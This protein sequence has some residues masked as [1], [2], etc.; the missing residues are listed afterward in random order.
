MAKQ[1]ITLIG[2]GLVGALLAQQLA[3]RGFA[4]EVYEKYPDPRFIGFSGGRSINLALAERGLQALRT[5]GLADDVL[6]HA[7]MMRGRMVH[8]RDGSTS[9]QRYGVDDSEVIW[10]VSRGT[11]NTLLLDAAEAA[12]A[13]IHFGQSPHDIDF[14]RQQMQVTDAGGSTRRVP[15]GML[16]GADG[17]GSGVRAAMNAYAPLGERVESLGHGYK[18]LEIP[19]V[20]ELP[21][22][23]V[24]GS[25]AYGQFA[26]E[27]HALHIWPRGGYMCIALPNTEG[28]FTVTL[29][30]PND[31][32]S[33]SFASLPDAATAAAFFREDF[34]GLLPLMPKFVED[35][36]GHPV[37][38]LATLYLDRWHLDGRAL[39]IGDA[40]HAIVPF[41]GQGMN[42]GFEDTVVLTDLLAAAPNDSADVFA[43][44]QRI[45]QP[46][47]N[48][49]ATMALEN[50]VEMRD[51]VADSHYLAKRE[52]GVLLAERAPEHYMARYRMVTFTHLP[53]AYA[54]ERG[55]AQ[56]ALLDDL[57]HES[58]DVASVD[59]DAA[60]A[61]LKASLPPLPPLRHE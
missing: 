60:V 34:P 9:L 52:L 15:F 8:A 5:A 61:L 21:A 58:N 46:D 42:C 56:D 31:G 45:R 11:L 1:P 14:N 44:F 19:P 25:G 6:R 16:I 22:A 32:S 55:R 13:Q 49:I 3:Q 17:A 37:G 4:V 53:Y 30:L 20:D 51:S 47:A 28:S 24:R 26:I 57:L 12:G 23:L 48:A 27:P 2:G 35:Y 50:Y 59:L 7:V 41:H 33:P 39:L 43:E 54:L 18:E 38:M 29:F 10:S 36:D 40:A